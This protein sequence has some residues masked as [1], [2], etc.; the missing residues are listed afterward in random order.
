LI[1]SARDAQQNELLVKRYATKT[2]VVLHAQIQGCAFTV[3][4]DLEK[5]N[6]KSI[7]KR[8][9]EESLN[10]KDVLGKLKLKKEDIIVEN[11]IEK[12]E[13]LQ[14]DVP[15]FYVLLEAATATLGHSKAWMKKVAVEVYW[16]FGEQVSKT[17]PSGLSLP[18]GSFMIYGKKNFVPVHKM[19][20]GFGLLFKV[21]GEAGRR[22]IEKKENKKQ[23]WVKE[24]LF[25]MEE[26][27]M[28][29]Q[30]R[31]MAKKFGGEEENTG[32][33][34]E[35][36]ERIKR[37]KM[38]NEE[39]KE[40]EEKE[41]EKEKEEEEI[42]ESKDNGMKSHVEQSIYMEQGD[43]ELIETKFSKK[44]KGMVKIKKKTKAER[45][46]EKEEVKKED[47]KKMKNEEV[48]KK[49]TK[50]RTKKD[51]K[52]MKKYLEKYGDETKEET[53]IRMKLMGFKK[54]YIME[55]KKKDFKWN[56][57]NEPE[58][59]EGELLIIEFSGDE[60]EKKKKEEP[61]E[62]NESEKKEKKFDNS[63]K[64]RVPKN[65]DS[66]SEDEINEA[67]S[68]NENPFRQFT[69]YP[70]EGDTI[71][72]VIP[73][74]SAYMTLS[75]YKYKI[76]LIPGPTK[77]GKIWKMISSLFDQQRG[78]SESEKKMIKGIT[79]NEAVQQLIGGCK[80]QAPGL[81]KIVQKQK[82]AKK[83]NKKNKK[84]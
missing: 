60:E 63:K 82:R 42:K 71:S 25:G 72:D 78:M 58:S 35:A 1:I 41:E 27:E 11:V 47:E 5:L 6:L 2:D 10:D 65:I 24:N 22:E 12:V 61:K 9:I 4:K 3:I 40:E 44:K 8:R 79:D 16:V 49:K 13:S 64:I 29:S 69:G 80:V 23:E 45:K 21:E 55:K 34:W 48:V 73:V 26:G 18:T 53:E 70:K 54:N 50:K 84:K 68:S 19:E 31:K 7:R 43:Q 76:K 66:D 56:V 33:F 20:M 28:S 32:L 75:R 17:A 36:I 59:K 62:N 37:E 14:S 46:K 39:E 57:Q 15:P 77:R 83:K 51:R 38:G 81:Q 67:Q 30:N 74:C 52:K